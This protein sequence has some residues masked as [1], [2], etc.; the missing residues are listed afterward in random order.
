MKD[1]TLDSIEKTQSKSTGKNQ[2]KFDLDFMMKMYE[3]IRLSHQKEKWNQI[4]N[5]IVDIAISISGADYGNIQLLDSYS[6]KLKIVAHHGYPKWW[7][8]YWN[9]VSKGHGTCG[10]ALLKGK[11]IIVE[12]VEESLIFTGKDLDMQ[13][14]AGIQS[15]Q[16]TPITSHSGKPLG[17]FSTQFK[18]RHQFKQHELKLLDLLTYNVA[19]ILEHK[20]AIADLEKSEKRFRTFIA[21]SSDVVYRMS[22][23]WG[24]MRQLKG[25][26]FIP[27][28]YKP[29]NTWIDK[30]IDPD[31]QPEVLRVINEAIKNKS[32]FE[33]EHRVRRVDGS[34]G[35]TFSRAVPILDDDSE[36]IEWLG[37]A[38]DITE[39]KKTELIFEL[40]EEIEKLEKIEKKLL[41]TKKTWLK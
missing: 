24:E 41:E 9:T 6:S 7:L 17:M 35:L 38:K 39:L 5:E 26:D 23:D 13:L 36:I 27:D 18:K 16:S 14:K 30:Y 28:T 29:S 40:K 33:L 34:L 4:L 31:D 25:K 20:K 21:A 15:I 10:T 1:N 11:R 32:I 8:D 3:L 12:D 19:D 22:P 37:T 2:L